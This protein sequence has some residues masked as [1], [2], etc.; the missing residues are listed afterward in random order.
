[1]IATV[2]SLSRG[3]FRFEGDPLTVA[4]DVARTARALILYGDG[5]EVEM[6]VALSWCDKCSRFTPNH[7][8]RIGQ[9][10][11]R[12]RGYFACPVCGYVKPGII[13]GGGS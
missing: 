2:K 3:V 10:T 7:E 9:E 13:P 12:E 4:E 1:M 6:D 11:R 8:P 5:F